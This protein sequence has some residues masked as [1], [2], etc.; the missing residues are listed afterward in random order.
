MSNEPNFKFSDICS[1]CG[2]VIENVCSAN[3]KAPRTNL[4]CNL[5]QELPYDKLNIAIFD[6]MRDEF[7]YI[8]DRAKTK[9][10]EE[11]YHCNKYDDYYENMFVRAKDRNNDN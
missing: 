3:N 11:E 9:L 6:I 1:Y 4:Q 8:K 2:E 10:T 7:K 5:L